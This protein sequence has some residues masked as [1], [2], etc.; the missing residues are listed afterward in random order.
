[1]YNLFSKRGIKIPIALLFF[2]TTHTKNVQQNLKTS[3][4]KPV[5]SVVNI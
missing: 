1:M 5:G 3:W 2:T 4:K